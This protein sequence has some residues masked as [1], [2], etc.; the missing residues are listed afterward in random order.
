MHEDGDNGSI[1]GNRYIPFAEL[2]RLEQVADGMFRSQ[3]KAFAPG[4]GTSAYGG[5]VF[6]Q[7]VWAAAQTVREG[8]VIHNI[9][10]YFT[11]P[12]NTAFPFIYTVR[13]VRDGGRY[14]TRTVEVIQEHNKKGICFTCTCSFKKEG[15]AS[16]DFQGELDLREEYKVALGDQRPDE[17]P[18]APSVDSPWYWE[19]SAENNNYTD[20]FPGLSLRKVDMQA[21]NAPRKPLDRRQLQFYT[22]IG[23]MPPVARAANLHACAHLYAS[24][25]NGLFLI[26]NHLGA[27]DHFT[28]MATLSHS[29]VFHVRASELEMAEHDEKDTRKWYCQETRVSR[30]SGGRGMLEGR[31]WNERGVHIASMYQDGL[32][33]LRDRALWLSD[34][35]EAGKTKE[36]L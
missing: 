24:D 15:E 33:T 4:G 28:A 2:I 32:V 8:F 7:A 5:H 17:W 36:K 6:A 11:L 30:V 18:E 27:G 22:T 13:L 35:S 19:A 10:G 21:Y 20:P 23:S 31:I 1:N 26:P 25:R 12:G 3:A 14:C 9:T 34:S 29:V 16:A